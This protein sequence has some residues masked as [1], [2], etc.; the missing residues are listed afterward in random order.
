MSELVLR[1]TYLFDKT[2][3]QFLMDQNMKYIEGLKKK[4]LL[5]LG[6]SEYQTLIF[7]DPEKMKYWEIL[8]FENYVSELRAISKKEILKKYPKINLQEM[9]S[10]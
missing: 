5:L 8:E 1:G 4:L 7:Y 2:N 3:K 6:S 10:L 9:T